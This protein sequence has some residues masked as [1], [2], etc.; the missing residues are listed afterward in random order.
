MHD[1]KLMWVMYIRKS[2]SYQPTK[3]SHLLCRLPGSLA[4]GIDDILRSQ[5]VCFRAMA[6]SCTY[7]I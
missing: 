4:D 6:I 5:M 2:I 3:A 1:D 7:N